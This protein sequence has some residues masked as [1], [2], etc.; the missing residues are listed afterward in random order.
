MLPFLVNNDEYIG[1]FLRCYVADLSVAYGACVSSC[2]SPDDVT[3]RERVQA[4]TM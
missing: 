4:M 1:S 2:C 3:T